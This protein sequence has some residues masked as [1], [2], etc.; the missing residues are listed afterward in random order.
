[1]AFKRV[2]RL[3]EHP[4]IDRTALLEACHVVSR[5]AGLLFDPE[6]QACL[7]VESEY[8]RMTGCTLDELQEGG[9]AVYLNRIHPEDI[10]FM[11]WLVSG[12][13]STC[14]LQ[15]HTMVAQQEYRIRHRDG[16]WKW[17]RTQWTPLVQRGRN[18][19]LAVSWDITL[20]RTLD[21]EMFRNRTLLA[22]AQKMGGF[23]CFECHPGMGDHF[24]SESLY[25]LTGRDAAKGPP[26]L[27]ELLERIHPEDRDAFLEW[28]TA[29]PH[30]GSPEL[31]YRLR[32]AA[33]RFCC[34]H[35]RAQWVPQAGGRAGRILG[36]CQDVT[37]SRL[38][39]AELRESVERFHE[40]A[41]RLPQSVFET[42]AQGCFTY[43][44]QCGITI[45]GYT[46]EEI[47]GRPVIHLLVPEDR[48]RALVDLH[49]VMTGG[50]SGHEY[51]AL[52]KDGTS[53][54]VMVHSSPIVRSGEATGIRGILV[55]LSEQ[56]RTRE[57]R[58]SLQER[59]IQAEKMEAIGQLAGG[60]AHDFN[61]H[62]SAI[63]GFAE[64]LQ[65]QLKGSPLARYAGNILKSSQRSAELTKQLLAFARKGKYLTV[66]VDV[67]EIVHEVLQI[68]EHSI[69]RRILLKT[70]LGARPSLT[71][72][73][74][75]QIQNALM[76]LAI[77]ARDAMPEG[78]ELWIRTAVKTLDEASC[79]TLPYELAPGR[80]LELT[81]S[82]TGVGMDRETQK[83]AF[84]PFFTTKE[85]GR[86]TGLGLASVYGIVKHHRGAIEV[87]SEL[88]VGTSFTLFLPLHEAGAADAPDEES[89]RYASSRQSILVVEDEPMVGE[90]LLEMLG[91]LG[92]S[93]TL[94]GD[95]LE[96]VERYRERWK[97]VDLVILDMVMPHLSGKD[98][99]RL[100]R[101]VNPEVRVLLSSGYS[102][103]GEAQVLL[104]EGA[105]GFLQK[106]YFLLELSQAL[107]RIFPEGQ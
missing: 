106:P 24:W 44:N 92:Y 4:D 57:E 80:F 74:P 14:L 39:E 41:G 23:G 22:E 61:N 31:E 53:Y 5:G 107:S 89:L 6:S 20:G 7:W 97:T 103:E 27:E 30:G 81:V 69:D 33:D 52:R 98:T 66:E 96:A 75:T 40:L 12:A 85:T 19:I 25:E 79:A 78:G 95:G 49:G 73:D 28:R 91:Q 3:I 51:M 37:A 104:E 105:I 102:V 21:E 16:D 34:I 18:L 48:E 26:D 99:F 55:D 63:M 60:V 100:L 42:D 2:D 43:V 68:L 32:G 90:M 15:D 9:L 47:L 72:G 58:R 88:G 36:V 77:N 94:V 93:A 56:R 8:A 38:R 84:D 71:L 87:M 83:R 62:L 101:E 59:L 70:A 1:M 29:L 82:D 45:S 64:M 13:P 46:E 67:H 76:N 17:V 35:C 50:R 10:P 86:G 54:P 11:G 65:D